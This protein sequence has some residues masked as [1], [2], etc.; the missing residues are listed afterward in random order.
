M[1]IMMFLNML[2]QMHNLDPSTLTAHPPSVFSKMYIVQNVELKLLMNDV[3]CDGLIDMRSKVH[4]G[5]NECF[6]L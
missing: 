3:P 4:N 1:I 6:I 2:P 5:P